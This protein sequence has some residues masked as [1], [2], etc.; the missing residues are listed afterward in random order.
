M[1]K[2]LLRKSISL[3][4]A[5]VFVLQQLP[6]AV[7]DAYAL[8]AG[9]FTTPFSP[10]QEQ[11][12]AVRTFITA[13]ILRLGKSG[14]DFENVPLAKDLFSTV[15]LA[16]SSVKGA[17]QSK[18]IDVRN[19][20]YDGE[21]E[22]YVLGCTVNG[23]PFTA[24]FKI[25]GGQPQ[26]TSI[27][28]YDPDEALFFP[29]VASGST[30]QPDPVQQKIDE[31]TQTARRIIREVN[32]NGGRTNIT[33]A[34]NA[35]L[36]KGLELML[37][38]GLAD[39]LFT[40][41]PDAPNFFTR[42]SG[43]SA[44][45]IL[46]DNG[47]RVM[48]RQLA[49][50][51]KESST[52]PEAMRSD[53]AAVFCSIS[54]IFYPQRKNSSLRRMANIKCEFCYG[55]AHLLDESNL[56]YHNSWA[57]SLSWSRQF[58]DARREFDLLRSKIENIM[59]AAGRD[60]RYQARTILTNMMEAIHNEMRLEI[61]DLESQ[62]L[63]FS[64]DRKSALQSSFL[65]IRGIFDY[66]ESLSAS[67]HPRTLQMI[68][69]AHCS[70]ARLLK[71]EYEYRNSQG[72]GFRGT[73]PISLT[74]DIAEN[75]RIGLH[76]LITSYQMARHKDRNGAPSIPTKHA[77]QFLVE[78][79]EHTSGVLEYVLGQI[80]NELI[81][82]PY[83][84]I[85]HSSD[86]ETEIHGTLRNID[87]A[88]NHVRSAIGVNA[89]SLQANTRTKLDRLRMD[90]DDDQYQ[91]PEEGI[92]ANMRQWLK[93]QEEI[94]KKF[95]EKLTDYLNFVIARDGI[96]CTGMNNWR[97]ALKGGI[98]Q[99]LR[100]LFSGFFAE[101][102]E[103]EL[104]ID[105]AVDHIIE[106]N[107]IDDNFFM[108]KSAYFNTQPEADRTLERILRTA[109][110][111]FPRQ[112]DPDEMRRC[113]LRVASFLGLEIVSARPVRRGGA[114][115]RILHQNEF[116]DS[117]DVS[118]ET[119]FQN[120]MQSVANIFH[121]LRQFQEMNSVTSPFFD[122]DQ[123]N[124][125][126][127][128]LE[129]TIT[130]YYQ[131]AAAFEARGRRWTDVKTDFSERY[132]EI[133]ARLSGLE[134][135]SLR[136]IKNSTAFI[137]Q[138]INVAEMNISSLQQQYGQLDIRWFDTNFASINNLVVQLYRRLN[139]LEAASDPGPITYNAFR[140][141]FGNIKVTLTS[142][143]RMVE[144]ISEHGPFLSTYQR[145]FSDLRES[146]EAARSLGLRL[147]NPYLTQDYIETLT[148]FKDTVIQNY[149]LRH[150]P[151]DDARFQN[152]CGAY[153]RHISPRTQFLNSLI[154][155]LDHADRKIHELSDAAR[156]L[157]I[158]E[159]EAERTKNR[160]LD[161]LKESISP[162]PSNF[163]LL[164]WQV[165]FS[166]PLD[167]DQTSQFILFLERKIDLMCSLKTSTLEVEDILWRVHEAKRILQGAAQNSPVP[168]QDKI[169]RIEELERNL[170]DTQRNLNEIFERISGIQ[171]AQ[172]E[173]F[174]NAIQQLEEIKSNEIPGIIND[175]HPKKAELYS[176]WFETLD[177]DIDILQKFSLLWLDKFL[178]GFVPQNKKRD[179]E[180]AFGQI[181]QLM[182]SRT[183]VSQNVTALDE[184]FR[185]LTVIF[186]DLLGKYYNE[187]FNADGLRIGRRIYD[188]DF[189]RTIGEVTKAVYDDDW[190]SRGH[191]RRIKHVLVPIIDEN[192]MI[193]NIELTLT[194]DT[195]GASKLIIISPNTQDG[196][197]SYLALDHF[198]RLYKS[199]RALGSGASDHIM[200]LAR[201]IQT[202]AKSGD[203]DTRSL[204]VLTILNIYL[205]LPVTDEELDIFQVPDDLR[206]AYYSQP[207]LEETNDIDD[208]REI[209]SIYE[210]LNAQLTQSGELAASADPD[211]AG[212]NINPEYCLLLLAA[213]LEHYRQLVTIDPENSFLNNTP[214][215]VGNT[216]LQLVSLDKIKQLSRA[217]TSY[218][219]IIRLLEDKLNAIRAEKRSVRSSSTYVDPVKNIL[220]QDLDRDKAAIEH[221]IQSC[222]AWKERH[223]L[224]HAKSAIENFLQSAFRV[225]NKVSAR[226]YNQAITLPQMPAPFLAI[227]DKDSRPVLNLFAHYPPKQDY[228]GVY[229]DLKMLDFKVYEKKKGTQSL[230][231]QAALNT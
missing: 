131:D 71:I 45:D 154:G 41:I 187:F 89:F 170:L 145:L 157:R 109:D 178:G 22:E 137:R 129:Y 9:H 48:L 144:S 99:E 117:L 225:L 81:F 194:R 32:N 13:N 33:S 97:S 203:S 39:N 124:D 202:R 168:L 73:S 61:M 46:S 166:I 191:G 113:I 212:I 47:N 214:I 79:V 183:D 224:Q 27:E 198:Q 155:V 147:D 219:E 204:A 90:W 100:G 201:L 143:E 7:P 165:G 52:Y 179:I 228:G 19:V 70:M 56:R 108:A 77:A 227:P 50:K 222:T 98:F 206:N 35:A 173:D 12:N 16:D 72:Q 36:G 95:K 57:L 17:N 58:S 189:S 15:N 14:Y 23:V 55:V 49:E 133:E 38:K 84:K 106:I 231:F 26:F 156:P 87:N 169:R 196:S 4:V 111:L 199:H 209:A 136:A 162:L 175:I 83:E 24:R 200:R 115:I 167:Q 80:R 159:G 92:L 188:R 135:S 34:D 171:P 66:L 62:P 153:F 114:G 67:E 132:H 104:F 31:A 185:E 43:L 139:E 93:L 101:E 116:E 96:N 85:E 21:K 138:K 2:N 37:K 215:D 158:P 44:Q 42:I 91:G 128:D 221:V 6:A 163:S 86:R 148:A 126:T 146:Q 164:Q 218:E 150:I 78:A 213:C 161:V 69:M 53:L 125:E 176:I 60:E 11:A 74:Y 18:R 105:M 119:S 230:E 207:Q 82:Y 152:D 151:F 192:G 226:N 28:K 122:A 160:I 63:S 172:D 118:R 107:G 142:I 65:E 130:R 134:G 59:A 29:A 216:L 184:K 123:I 208:S 112:F 102:D 195:Q 94:H 182:R 127:P 174:E 3:I 190:Y 10:L 211:L 177:E 193:T 51:I 110:T 186:N 76:H 120:R 20:V 8:S 197:P 103:L 181:L 205:G 229:L 1:N 180:Q 223:S 25:D 75:L 217:P 88:L 64:D 30:G 54:E 68:G 141:M 40:G 121:S 140:D 5:C 220:I 149:A 210:D